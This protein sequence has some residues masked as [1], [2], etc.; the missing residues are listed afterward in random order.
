[1][2]SKIS[3]VKNFTQNIVLSEELTKDSYACDCYS[4]DTFITFESIDRILYLIYSNK[5]NSIISYNLIN[6]KI[7][8]EIK[9]AHNQFISSFKYYLD[10]SNKRDLI[11]SISENSI[12]LWNIKSLE[13]LLYINNICKRY[14]KIIA[15]YIFKN[16]NQ[17]SIVSSDF[18]TVKA[19]DL[20]GNQIKEIENS[21]GDKIF[22]IDN[23]FDKNSSKNYIIICFKFMIKSYDFHKNKIYH[24]YHNIKY[25][26]NNFVVNDDD[27][28][29]I[30]LIVPCWDNIIRIWDFHSGELI[31]KINIIFN[32]DNH[33]KRYCFLNNTYLFA[34]YDDD[35]IRLI[36]L[37][38]GYAFK[39]L[40]GHKDFI[41]TI[42]KINH[43]KYGECLISQ[44]Y[45]DDQIKLWKYNN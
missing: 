34:G 42:R 1:M 15:A 32:N 2:G 12:K 9:R 30:K 21:S 6:F 7:M 10:I 44:G 27:E 5:N 25:S 14:Q 16:N 36:N 4:F 31:K 45:K 11:I 33:I 26:N 40:I 3:F 13:C 20:N 23:Y 24:E 39:K 19:F 37:K 18:N 29:I 41:L 43:P 35:S 22:Y 17:L 28:K 38:F 8:N